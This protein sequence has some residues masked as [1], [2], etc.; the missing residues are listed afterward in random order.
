MTIYDLAKQLDISPGTVSRALKNDPKVASR[1]RAQVNALA[2][3]YGFKP[4]EQARNLRLGKSS[5]VAVVVYS[6]TSEFWGGIVHAIEKVFGENYSVILCNSDGSL[7]KEKNIIQLLVQRQVAAVF[8]QPASVR[9][10]HLEEISRNGIRVVLF[11]RTINS[12]LPFVKGDDVKST[13]MLVNQCIDDGHRRLAILSF[14]TEIIGVKDRVDSFWTAVKAQGIERNCADF[15]LEEETQEAIRRIVLPHALEFSAIFC[16]KDMLAC[17]LM[18]ELELA[19]IPNERRPSLVCWSNNPALEYLSPPLAS[20][21]V[22]VDEMGTTAARY[23]LN[24]EK[25]G[26]EQMQCLLEQEIILRASYHTL[27][28]KKGEL[29]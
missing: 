29:Q 28:S 26:A 10:E 5:L 24:C 7:E 22:P 6:T 13:N 9:L 17:M 25:G 20:V 2:Q 19:G 4:S 15:I 23:V 12:F 8:I 1:T 16:T 27:T 3:S 18:K 14:K 21:R 11:E